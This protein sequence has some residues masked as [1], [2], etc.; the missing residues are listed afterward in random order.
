MNTTADMQPAGWASRAAILDDTAAHQIRILTA[1]ANHLVWSCTCT[2]DR[3]NHR[4]L[5]GADGLTADDI[6]AAHQTHAATAAPP[7][8]PVQLL[9]G[10]TEERA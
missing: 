9:A 3:G 6:L 7:A 2:R 1:G 10:L 4:P 8:E 5:G